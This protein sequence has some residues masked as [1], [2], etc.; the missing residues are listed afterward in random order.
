MRN[1][2]PKKSEYSRLGDFRTLK[3][4]FLL[5][6]NI[7][8]YGNLTFS[9]FIPNFSAQSIVTIDFGRINSFCENLINI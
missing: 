1:V 9:I 2:E 4:A 5:L 7:Q 6:I 3:K 8:F